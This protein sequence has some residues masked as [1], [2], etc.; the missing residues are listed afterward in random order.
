MEIKVANTILYCRHWSE[1]VAFYR[2]DLKFEVSYANEWFVEFKLNEAACLSV[3]DADRAWVG[4]SSGEGVMVSLKVD[5]LVDVY[6]E[7]E[8]LEL[9]PTPVEEVLGS[10]VFSIFDPEGVRLE[11]WSTTKGKRD[12]I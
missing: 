12:D 7:M 10:E 11:F 2:D 9:D 6:L 1:C 8:M 4:P 5:N 3:V